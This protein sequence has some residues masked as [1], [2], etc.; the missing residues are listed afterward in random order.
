[1]PELPEVET[2]I[3]GLQKK[4]LKRTFVDTWTDSPKLIKKPDFEVFQKEIKGKKILD[5]R[6]RGKNIIFDLSQG[7]SLLIHQKLTGHLLYGNWIL[8]NNVW[9]S[10]DKKMMDRV[11]QYIHLMFCL[12]NQKMLALSDLRKFAKVELWKTQE[13]K[14]SKEFNK[15][16]PEPLD[17]DF[18]FDKFVQV[19]SKRKGK[20]KQVLLN[21]EVLVGIGNIYSDEALW[22]AKIHPFRQVSTLTNSELKKL[23]SYILEV[24]KE[25][26]KLGGESF[27]DYRDLHGK[28]GNFDKLRMVYQRKG[29][30]CNYCQNK[31][32]RVKMGVRSA[33]F[34]PHCQKL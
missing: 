34:C 9:K 6:R 21:Q 25:S 33:H 2:T 27:K 32:E 11:N 15:L 29:Q 14:E 16:G 24:L 13:L 10:K 28:K 5:I 17:P 1:M 26:I 3:L 22:R 19:L 30:E 7:Y 12:D 18:T 4:V 20:I 23:Y 31:I 8:E